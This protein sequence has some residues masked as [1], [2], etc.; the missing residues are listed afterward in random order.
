MMLSYRYRWYYV[1]GLLCLACWVSV[2]LIFQPGL[3]H[4][5]TLQE[6]ERH[7]Q[8][9]MVSVAQ[10]ITHKSASSYQLVPPLPS[11]LA[12]LLLSAHQCGLQVQSTR[13]KEGVLHHHAVH[14]VRLTLLGSAEEGAHFLWQVLTAHP[15]GRVTHFACHMTGADSLHL[16]IALCVLPAGSHMLSR[17]VNFPALMQADLNPHVFCSLRTLPQ[18]VQDHALPLSASF[19]NMRLVGFFKSDTG[20]VGLIALPNGTTFIVHL[21]D[22]IGREGAVVIA[23]SRHQVMVA[24]DHH[25]EVIHDTT[26][27]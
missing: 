15:E 18:F 2:W 3:Q 21:R 8:Q 9:R 7:L 5:A 19:H 16:Q 24:L 1:V 26:L 14:I 13:I 17:S 12:S 4:L 25:Q 23:I 27:A 20:C 6:T 11:V 22:H 10:P